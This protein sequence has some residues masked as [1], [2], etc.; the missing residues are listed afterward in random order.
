MIATLLTIVLILVI[1]AI[2]VWAIRQFPGDATLLRLASVVIVAVAAIFIA[3]LLFDMINGVVEHAP[4][5][6]RQR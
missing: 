2:L 1:A 3:I 5:I 4:M 6:I